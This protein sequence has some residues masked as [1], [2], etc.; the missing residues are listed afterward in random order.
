MNA[1]Q[2]DFNTQ[3]DP[4]QAA[5]RAVRLR[6][7]VA[8]ALTLLVVLAYRVFLAPA[9]AHGEALAY[10][11]CPFRGDALVIVTPRV[12]PEDTFPVRVHEEIHASQCRQFGPWRYRFTNLSSRGKLS[13]EAPAYCAGARARLKQGMPV[14]RVRE[15]LL[16]DAEAAFRGAQ[17]SLRV[18]E[19]L[20]VWCRD[21][22]G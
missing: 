19:A 2:A 21:I 17:D 1:R 16:D 20:R 15:R 12:A 18:R 14:A 5:R 7:L 13:L 3:K 10:T 11:T 9:D 6:A 4:R 8:L 22:V